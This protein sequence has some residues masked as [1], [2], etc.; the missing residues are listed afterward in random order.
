MSLKDE[1]SRLVDLLGD[2]DE[3][4]V[5]EIVRRCIAAGDAPM[6]IIDACEA[7]MRLV[8]ERYQDGRYFISGLVM[9]GEILRQVMALVLPFLKEEFADDSSGCVLLGTVQGDLHDIG[10]D[11][12]KILLRCYGFTVVDLGVDVPPETFLKRALE[13][14]PQIVAMSGL[15]TLSHEAMRKTIALL[16]A[17]S[18]DD[19]PRHSVLIG[20]SYIDDRVC[21]FVGADYWGASAVDGLH[22][23]QQ[24][25]EEH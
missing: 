12:V 1:K 25:V 10:K 4:S 19:L 2:L 7:G 20:G 5:L 15:L 18:G 3:N 11:L 21:Q 24:I 13:L 14:K 16:K 8:G 22:I 17:E 6:H 9:A 23:C